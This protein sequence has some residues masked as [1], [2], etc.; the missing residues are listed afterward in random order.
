MLAELSAAVRD[1]RVHPKE[2]VTEALRRIEA[3]DGPI[4]SVVAL[5]ADDAL[6]DAARSARE[7]P[8][9][10]IPFLVKDLADCAG[11]RTTYG[12]K[13]YADA[14]PAAADGVQAGRLRAAGAIPIGKANTPEFGWIGYTSNLVFG[15]TRNPW[16]LER[17]PGGSSGGSSAA[18]A[19]GLVPI[20]T[21]SDGGGSVRIPASLCG[22]V[23]YKPTIGG[24]GRDASPRWMDYST[25]GVLAHTVAD[26]VTEAGALLGPSAGDV[27]AVPAG[28]IALAP[29][30]PRRALLCRSLR[31]AVDPVIE[32]DLLSAAAT[33]EQLGIGVEEIENPIP[34]AFMAW[35]VSA[36]AEMAQSLAGQRDRWD[37][38]DPGLRA[39]LQYGASVALDDYV[40][41][42][43]QRYAACAVIDRLLGTDTVLVTPTH[44]AQSWP[45]A[46]PWPMAVNG[47]DTPGV[48][49][50]TND[51]NLTGHPAV[52]VPIGR[53]DAGV[54]FGMQVVAPRWRDGLALGTAAA[55]ETA[56]PWPLVADGYE[57]FPI[58]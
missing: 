24:I 12:S 8:L 56:R 54:P 23:G 37:E 45:A 11:L 32:A 33:I 4:G 41:A 35:I 44:N 16:N 31:G 39:M 2:L 21:A 48:A 20:A 6:D 43:R 17:S 29:A 38:V 53:D 30:R 36:T 14:P 49:V 47:V 5:R 58:P 28:A 40:A 18:L 46:G 7:G 25:S 50:N 57:P 22:L 1:G 52:S 3:D 34:D 15:T 55:L 10:G 19:A 51:F 9:A 13:L 42:R 27:L 26:V